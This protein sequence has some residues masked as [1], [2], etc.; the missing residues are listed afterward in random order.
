MRERLASL[1]RAGLNIYHLGIKELRSLR[2][3]PVLVFLIVY[4]FSWG[5]YEVATGV[6]FEVAN[7]SVAIIDEDRS[8][9]SREIASALL[10][11][12]F[13]NAVTI[14]P[15]KAGEAMDEG[16]YTFILDIPPHF[17]R[18]L[19]SGHR[20]TLQLN[21]DA[22]AMS[23]AGNG[24]GYIQSIVTQEVSRALST[25]GKKTPAEADLIARALFNPNLD[26]VPFTAVMEVINNITLLSVIL[27]GAALI[28]EREHGTLE[29]LLVMPVTAI[30]IM[31]SKLWANG[32]VIVLAATLSLI[33][34]VQGVLGVR[35]SGSLALFIAGALL[36]Q[37]SVTALGILLATFTNSMAQYGLL[38]MPVL[39]LMQLLSG[40]STP[41]ESMPVWLQNTMQLSPSTHFVT[42]SQAILYRGAELSIVWPQLAVLAGIGGAFFFIALARFRKAI[43]RS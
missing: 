21:V 35:T 19:L 43:I 10:P 41:L 13:K 32:L 36:Y 18:D 3:D 9:L 12:Y 26:S 11:P 28:R 33:F 42:F 7:A 25:S 24:A 17:E 16:R 20:P 34:M 40:S 4:A 14:D 2:S 37:F 6:K 29:H 38:V 8:P 39:I 5:I 22:T 31:S 1:R 27:A 23:M 15:D 30:E